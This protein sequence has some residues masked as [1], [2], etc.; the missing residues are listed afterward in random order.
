MRL[1]TPFGRQSGPR[2][3][4]DAAGVSRLEMLI[5]VIGIALLILLTLDRLLPLRGQAEAA[6]VMNAEGAMRSALGIE[7][8]AR[9]LRVGFEALPELAGSNPMDLL[10]ERPAN[11]QGARPAVDA[12]ELAPGAWAFDAGRGVLVYRVRFAQYFTGPLTDPA[13]AEWRIDVLYAG[14]PGQ[15]ENIRGVQLTQL[16]AGRWAVD[17]QEPRK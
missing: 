8:A 17:Q 16:A 3:K 7:T 12:H 14:D 13:R 6:S 15:P 2:G 11:D 9:V 4:R 1:C 10:A 5:A